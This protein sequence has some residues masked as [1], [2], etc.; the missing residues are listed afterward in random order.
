[1]GTGAPH[2]QPALPSIG[3]G[4]PHLYGRWQS[5]PAM[6]REWEGGWWEVKTEDHHGGEAG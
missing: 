1:M 6:D 5:S 3:S 4:A 2:A